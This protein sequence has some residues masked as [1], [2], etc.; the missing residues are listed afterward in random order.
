MAFYALLALFPAL[1]ALISIWALAFDPLQLDTIGLGPVVQTL[2]G[3]LR[4]PILFGVALIVLA[5]IYR[6]GPSRTPARWRWVSWGA[7]VAT[8]IWTLGSIAFSLY[9]QNFGSYN[10]TYGSLGAVVILLMWFWLSAFIVLLGAELNSEVEHQ[11]ERD[12]TTGPPQPL[13]AR[14]AYVADHVGE[15]P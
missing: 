2:L 14:G 6:Y 10:E 5:I 12:S 1:G 8:A 9:V 7:A 4:W 13:G 11:T 15:I 3:L